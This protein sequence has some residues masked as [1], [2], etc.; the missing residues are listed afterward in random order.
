MKLVLASA[1]P[2]RIELLKAMGLDFSVAASG[3]D[4]ESI[5]ADHPR[6]F[7]LRA[8]FAKASAVAERLG[9]EEDAWVLG[10]DTVVTR[11][12]KLFGK[13]RDAAEAKRMLAELSGRE[14]QVITGVALVRCGAPESH[15]QSATTTVRFRTVLFEEIDRYVATGR[16]MDKAGAYGIQEEAGDFVDRIEG[17]YWNVVGLPC[18]LVADLVESKAGAR[19]RAPLPPDRWR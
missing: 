18:D 12:L 8:A 19:C 11:N 10:A 13:P 15:L 3:V 2:R 6:T 1:S 5:P 7:A 14:H 9:D 4:E 16:P 17:D